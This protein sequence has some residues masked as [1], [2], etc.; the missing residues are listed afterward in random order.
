MIVIY[1]K[2]FFNKK[3]S[4]TGTTVNPETPQAEAPSEE[5]KL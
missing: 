1:Q 2:R 3:E 5:N 4:V